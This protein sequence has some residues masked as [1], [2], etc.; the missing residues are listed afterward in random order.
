MLILSPHQC[1]VIGVLL[2]KQVTTPDQYPLSLN[3]LVT[4]CNQ[5]SNRHPVYAWSAVEVQQLVDQLIALKCI[6]RQEDKQGRVHKYQHRFCNS[7]FGDLQLSEQQQALLCL[8]FLRGAQTAGELKTRSQRLAEFPQV[9]EVEMVLQQ[10]ADF[11]GECLVEKLPREAGKRECRYRHLFIQETAT[12]S[13]AGAVQ[14]NNTDQ[15]AEQQ[16]SLQ[17][18]VEQ[19]ERQIENLDQRLEKFNA[20]LNESDTNQA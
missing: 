17:N 3:A 15:A 10:L 14:H 19:L 4:G 16:A 8:L 1:R 12:Q 18:R 20:L 11:K 9:G 13:D 6:Q 7:P 5:K 2:E